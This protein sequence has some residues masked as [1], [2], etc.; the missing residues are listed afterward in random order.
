MSSQAAKIDDDIW[1]GVAGTAGEFNGLITQF[2]TDADI[3]KI[4]SGITRGTDTA[5]AAV[6]EDNVLAFL[7]LALSSM[8]DCM[9]KKKK[10]NCGGIA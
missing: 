10:R 9:K 6:T 8:P 1:N 2:A 3:I 7:K 5:K 4:G